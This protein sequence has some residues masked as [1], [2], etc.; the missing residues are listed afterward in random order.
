MKYM[1]LETTEWAKRLLPYIYNKL[2]DDR[3]IVVDKTVD[4]DNIPD[5]DIIITANPHIAI[6]EIIIKKSKAKSLFVVEGL[7]NR[8]YTQGDFVDKVAVWGEN[9]KRDFIECGWTKDKIVVTGCPRFEEHKRRALIALPAYSKSEL[10]ND[11]V[12]SDIRVALE[13]NNIIVVVKRHPGIS[14]EKS[15]ILYSLRESDIVITGASTI[16]LHAILLDKKVIYFDTAVRLFEREKHFKS[17][18]KSGIKICNNIEEIVAETK[19]GEVITGYLYDTYNAA[20]NIIKL[21]GDMCNG[22]A[23]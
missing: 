11:K 12:V 6:D 1:F 14:N 9:M 7:N 20:D 19:H 18:V 3:F 4:P 10:N 23:D 16:A 17:L 15:D 2:P 5:F 22:K 8:R 13:K 21:M